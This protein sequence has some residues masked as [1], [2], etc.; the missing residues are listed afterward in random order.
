VEA[1]QTPQLCFT[2]SRLKAAA[3][4][5]DAFGMP[6]S[7]SGRSA[8]VFRATAGGD[9]VALR[10][11][12]REVSGQKDRYQKLQSYLTRSRPS[13][14]VDLAY[15]DSEIHIQGVRYPLI[16]MKWVTGDPL[17]VWVNQHLQRDGDL[18][19]LAAEWLEI[20]I[21]MER[22]GIA[23]GDLDN[24]NC[25]IS[26]DGITL[27]DYDGFLVPSFI[28]TPSGEAGHPNFQHPDRKG[29]AASNMD[30]FPAL[31]TYLSLLALESDG[32]LWRYH[33]DRNLIFT[34]D[35]Y[36]APRATPIWQDLA[37]NSDP[38]VRRL[39]G[40]L[41]D[42]CEAS[43]D[44][45]QPLSQV[46]GRS[47][48]PMRDLAGGEMPGSY[49]AEINTQDPG[50]LLFLI[51]QSGSM[52]DVFAGSSAIR[53]ADTAADAINKLLMDVVLRCTQNIGEGPRD[54]FD[55]GVIGYGS[56]GGVGSCL[57]G[58]L[59]GRTLV[60]IGELANNPLRVMNRPRQVS[61]SAGRE[62]ETSVKFP[63]WL[64][65]VAE[66]GAPMHEAID[67][68]TAV[69]KSW[70]DEHPIS[71][72]PIVINIAGGEMDT[73][74]AAA[75]R[76]L[77]SIR[78]ADGNV[79]L[80]NFHLSSTTMPPISFPS[81]PQRFPD[82]AARTLFEMSS[83]IP[84][85]IVQELA[86]E[87][88]ATAPGAR[89]YVINTD[90]GPL[91]RYFNIGTR[92]PIEPD[93]TV[94]VSERQHPRDGFSRRTTATSTRDQVFI[95]YSHADGKWLKELQTHL[96]PYLRSTMIRVWDDS[97]IGAGANWKESI[98]NA[99]TLTKVA[100][101]LVSPAF[102]ASNFIAESELPPLLEAARSEGV[103]IL[104]VPVR[105]S[106]YE[107]TPIA[108]YQAAHSPDKPL[109]SLSAPARDKALVKICEVIQRAYQQ[110]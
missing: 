60:S 83:A 100:V 27:I 73:N 81:S 24:T 110:Q 92:L 39:T 33:S 65:P 108:A 85:H 14:L 10:C 30:A 12:T 87:G 25:L 29:Y 6:F 74:P 9:D 38:T 5:T 99:L 64:D 45:L 86:R 75:A 103:T 2:S 26:R 11:F 28:G 84:W 49:N 13:Y 90:P 59:R 58:A 44:S 19:A 15:R 109:A 23:H 37:N 17:D 62:V 61:D 52:N 76:K 95:S 40:A 80:Y 31:V 47:V 105:F 94:E 97:H 16:E 42:M 7:A 89:G 51:D 8:C 32:S 98:E 72:P 68:A 20:V 18:A 107:I 34:A 3:F 41:A 55:V 66:D 46:V 22:R 102:L 63:V 35:D 93:A 21:D 91:I 71:Y 67:L 69:L 1:V 104:W 56:N 4:I 101:L 70:V 43:I 36:R 53:K 78:T 54:Y 106:S 48:L 88:Y 82:L 96:K 50:C 57:G 77:T 79:L